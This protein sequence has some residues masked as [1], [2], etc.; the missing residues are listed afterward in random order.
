MILKETYENLFIYFVLQ[1][2][3]AYFNSRVLLPDLLLCFSFLDIPSRQIAQKS[4]SPHQIPMTITCFPRLGATGVFTDPY[5]PP[6][7]PVAQSLY[8]PDE[9]INEHVRFP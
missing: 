7:G 2:K 3:K 1:K 5:H 9:I 6:Y 8:L 4:L